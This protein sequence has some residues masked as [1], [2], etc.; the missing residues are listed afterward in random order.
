MKALEQH[1]IFN[2]KE[3]VLDHIQG[4]ATPLTIKAR[5]SELCRE[6]NANGTEIFKSIDLN[7]R[8]HGIKI[9]LK[10]LNCS[11][12]EIDE[13]FD[14][15]S[16]FY[17]LIRHVA[18]T[19]ND[20]HLGYLVELISRTRPPF[21][22]LVL[23][24]SGTITSVLVGVFLHFNHKYLNSMVSWFN[25][26]FPAIKKFFSSAFNILKNVPI[27][28]AAFNTITLLVTWYRVLTHQSKSNEEKIVELSFKTASHALAITGYTLSF[29]AAG[30]VSFPIAILFVLR[31][32]MEGAKGI[33]DIIKAK[34]NESKE[35]ENNTNQWSFKAEKVKKT[36]YNTLR[37]RS[38]WIKIGAG[39]LTAAAVA[40]MV[41]FPPSLVLTVSC[42]A[43]IWLIDLTKSIWINNLSTKAHY[44]ATK[45]LEKMHP[46]LLDTTEICPSEL[47]CRKQMH[48]LNIEIEVLEHKRKSLEA[49]AVRLDLLREELGTKSQLLDEREQAI[50]QRYYDADQSSDSTSNRSLLANFGLFK[51]QASVTAKVP[52]NDEALTDPDLRSPLTENSIS[53][54]TI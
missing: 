24:L 45:A 16:N 30:V 33:Y 17:S 32:L 2:C 38:G 4:R 5:L 50:N 22:W 28:L 21:N 25:K 39:L 31:S 53:A 13:L 35:P 44:E 54:N 29:L 12:C 49:E 3:I 47:Y 1:Q 15:H 26:T 40:M 6:V 14:Q 10:S 19:K 23:M 43:F 20:E 51:D 27:F 11:D 42:L 7:R 18:K 46:L 8:D 9:L 34:I 52:A 41:F 48:N 36:I 37:S